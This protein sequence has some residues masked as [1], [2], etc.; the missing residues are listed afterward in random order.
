M[1]I[2]FKLHVFAL[3]MSVLPFLFDLSAALPPLYESLNE[4]KSLLNNPELAEK[5]GSGEPIKNIKRTENGFLVTGNR[6]TLNV[7][8]IFEPQ[9]HP[10]PSKFHFI[11]HDPEQI[12]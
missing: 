12:K 2:L 1:K 10:G 11:F 6:F 7:D 5:I 4:Y 9:N 3:I 8:L